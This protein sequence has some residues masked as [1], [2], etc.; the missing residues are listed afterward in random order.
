MTNETAIYLICSGTGKT[1]LYDLNVDKSQ[2]STEENI[3]VELEGPLMK[4]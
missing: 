2:S 1:F 3:F 4:I